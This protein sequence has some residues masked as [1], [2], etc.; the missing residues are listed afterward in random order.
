MKTVQIITPTRTEIRM[1]LSLFREYLAARERRF[2]IMLGISEAQP[3]ANN[4]NRIAWKMLA[5]GADY[6]LMID[7]D[8]VP[9]GFNPLDYVENDL[10]VLGFPN[11][12]WRANDECPISWFPAPPSDAGLVE[13]E[14]MGGGCLLIARR[15][16]E[17]PAM[18]GPFLD[19]WDADG[20]RIE[21]EDQ[22]FCRRAREAG[23]KVW[24]AMDRP[25]AHFKPV[26]LTTMWEYVE[27]V[28]CQS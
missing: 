11:P 26:E 8:T 21:S 5:D 13:V 9:R 1:E 28:R 20:L 23:F 24:C 27:R 10:D 19:F 7:S 4:R 17:H 18:R 14:E 22:S 3:V 15:V 2:R 6:V 25:I 12:T 16:L